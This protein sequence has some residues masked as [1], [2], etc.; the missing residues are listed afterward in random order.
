MFPSLQ[1]GTECSPDYPLHNHTISVEQ[2]PSSLTVTLTTANSSF[3]TAIL[4]TEQFPGLM[5]NQVFRVQVNACN[6]IGC[7]A[8]DS[9]ELS[10][11][12][13]LPYMYMYNNKLCPDCLLHCLQGHWIST[14]PVWHTPAHPHRC[15]CSVCTLM[16]ALP[17]AASSLPP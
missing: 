7:K 10:E 6:D 11:S 16:A 15:T 9:V 17:V 13:S 1:G 14:Q 5:A 12:T 4:T 2:L 3:F 8:S